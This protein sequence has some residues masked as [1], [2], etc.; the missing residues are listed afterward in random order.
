M[1]SLRTGG[2]GAPTSSG[3]VAVL[4]VA[5]ARS[6]RPAGRHG[7]GA[8]PRPDSRH[9]PPGT[10]RAH[11]SAASRSRSERS[12][13]C[14][15]GRR[16]DGVGGARGSPPVD[17]DLVGVAQPVTHGPDLVPEVLR[18]RSVGDATSPGSLR[19]VVGAPA[20]RPADRAPPAL[21]GVPRQVGRRLDEAVAVQCLQVMAHRARRPARCDRPGGPPWPGP[22]SRAARPAS[23]GSGGGRPSGRRAGRRRTPV[24]QGASGRC[25]GGVAGRYVGSWPQPDRVTTR[26]TSALV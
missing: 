16:D 19:E 24:R 18:L 1:A 14:P 25:P 17:S 15:T 4:R 5:P 11:P 6:G 10:R 23:A 7:S 8:D 20:E 12:A 26:R 13:S 22:R 21:P 9:G 2:G 3:S